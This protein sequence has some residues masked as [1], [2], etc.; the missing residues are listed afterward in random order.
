VDL[1]Q[2][3]EACPRC[4]DLAIKANFFASPNEGMKV[5][6]KERKK[7]EKKRKLKER[8]RWFFFFFL[9]LL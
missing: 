8:T 1:H 6:K 5:R 2:L 9:L 7:E 4:T 3:N